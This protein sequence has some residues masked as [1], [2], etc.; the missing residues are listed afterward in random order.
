MCSPRPPHKRK[1]YRHTEDPSL[2]RYEEQTHTHTPRSIF[3]CCVCTCVHE[4]TCVC[5]IVCVYAC[6]G[7]R[8][9]MLSTDT[10][11]HSQEETARQTT[12][13][14]HNQDTEKPRRRTETA[15]EKVALLPMELAKWYKTRAREGA[16]QP[17][18]GLQKPPAL[19]TVCA[20][21][22]YACRP[23]TPD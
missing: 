5:V 15:K 1:R 3:M 9:C 12:E 14:K 6:T 20:S 18:G 22:I 16:Q 23:C 8:I 17:A 13:H 10:E 2:P 7:V 11:P 19:E 4:Y 21:P